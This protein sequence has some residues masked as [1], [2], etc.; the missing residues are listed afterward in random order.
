MNFPSII[1]T[2]SVL[3]LFIGIILL[4]SL[5][6]LPAS[7][8]TLTPGASTSTSNTI[9]NG[10]PVYVTGIATGHPNSGLQVWLIGYNTVKISTVSV[11]SD[12]SYKY[13]ITS[14]D[15][16][17]LASGQY[18]VI[19]Q[20]PMM[21]G[22]FDIIYS[23]STG[24]VINRQMTSSGGSGSGTAIFQLT[25]G[26]SLQSTNAASALMA[27]INSQ[28][29]DDTF[30]TATFYI[31]PP[32]AFIHPVGDHVVGE[33]FTITGTTNLAVGDKLQVDVYSS[34]FAPTKKSQSGEYSGASGVVE[35]TAG[36]S[37]SNQWSFD[38]D[39]SGFKPDEYIVTVAGI[40][41]DVRGSATFN[42]LSATPVTTMPTTVITSTL[43]SPASTTPAAEV[44][45]VA[46]P[47][48]R[49]SPLALSGIFGGLVLAG[50][51]F[52]FKKD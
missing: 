20:H 30:A 21:N 27:A 38:V 2:K 42:I 14:T 28:N 22:Q 17:N 4:F 26:G 29:V 10:D 41:Q 1:S 45:P 24:Q 32:N 37:G 18:L 49:Q 51:F 8:I 25:S 35:V 15:T 40:I 39:A 19:V 11:N 43:V 46:V 16:Q 12:N 23:P 36:S 31:S 33:K 52:T 44:S 9:S 13:E 47:T 7:A 5:V 3:G 50:I 6:F 34:S 48:T